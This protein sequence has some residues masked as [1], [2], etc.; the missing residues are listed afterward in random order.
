[1][2]TIVNAV[3]WPGFAAL[4][5]FLVQRGEE[6]LMDTMSEQASAEASEG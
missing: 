6:D 4:Y 1:M 3:V 2:F 5:W